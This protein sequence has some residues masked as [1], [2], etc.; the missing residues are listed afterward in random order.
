MDAGII[1]GFTSVGLIGL[2]NIVMVS[3]SYGR[4]KQRVV[5][6]CGRVERLEDAQNGRTSARRK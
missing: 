1:V 5:D 4:L 3:V 2:V 6:L